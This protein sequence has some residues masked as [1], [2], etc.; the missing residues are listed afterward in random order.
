MS[1]T[2]IQMVQSAR[3]GEGTKTEAVLGAFYFWF[4]GEADLKEK[5]ILLTWQGKHVSI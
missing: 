2:E 1:S 4:S 3:L 5:P